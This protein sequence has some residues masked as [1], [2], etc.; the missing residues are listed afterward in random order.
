MFLFSSDDE[1]V[2]AK[3]SSVTIALIV[4][5]IGGLSVTAIGYVLYA[6]WVLIINGKFSYD[7]WSW[8]RKCMRTAPESLDF[9][10]NYE[11][12]PQKK[13]FI[14]Y[15][16]YSVI[17]RDHAEMGGGGLRRHAV[18]QETC[19]STRDPFFQLRT[20]DCQSPKTVVFEIFHGNKHQKQKVNVYILDLSP[21]PILPV[22]LI[23]LADSLRNIEIG[24]YVINYY[25]IMKIYFLLVL[26]LIKFVLCTNEN[27]TGCKIILFDHLVCFPV[28][29]KIQNVKD[30]LRFPPM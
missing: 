21:W 11:V 18:Y 27:A 9:I 2:T 22:S 1:P 19:R 28:N 12:L 10:I 13:K 4:L 6:R 16:G 30:P 5:F 7:P 17:A 23:W 3:S 14:N 29:Y 25:Y 8:I 24:K 26:P 15:W 20:L